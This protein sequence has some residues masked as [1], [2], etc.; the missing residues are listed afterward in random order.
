MRCEPHMRAWMC[1]AAFAKCSA[2]RA[3]SLISSRPLE[4]YRAASPQLNWICSCVGFLP[5]NRVT[6]NALLQVW[7][8]RL[9]A[10]MLHEAYWTTTCPSNIGKLQC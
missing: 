9:A 4:M 6:C 2:L 3:L 1:L 10:A 7:I 5:K 8:S